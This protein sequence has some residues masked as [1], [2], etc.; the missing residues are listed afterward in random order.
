MPREGYALARGWFRQIDL[1]ENP[2]LYDDP[3]DA[4]RVPALAR[5]ARRALGAAA[6]TPGS[7]RWAPTARPRCSAPGARACGRCTA[8]PTGRSTRCPAR[9]RSSTAGALTRFDHEAIAGHRRP[10][11]APAPRALEPLLA[12]RVRRRLPR[13]GAGRADDARGRAGGPLFPRDRARRGAL[14]Q[15][16][17]SR[18]RSGRV[19][20]MRLRLA[21]PAP[22]GPP[23]GGRR[24][25]RRRR[26]GDADAGQ[27]RAG[28]DRRD[29]HRDGH[30]RRDRDGR[31][32]RPTPAAARP[33][34]AAA[35]ATRRRAR[36]SSPPRAAS[37]AT[38]SPTRAPPARSAR[39][40]TRRSPTPRS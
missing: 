15:G 30:R 5:P 16:R 7:G 23:A 33:P 4:G 10:G 11:P 40:S 32:R 9:P 36:R 25:L 21:L 3:L 37:R 17:L 20:R 28:R 39:T 1:A 18:R 13:A 35:A 38:R 2:E 29:R 27:R 31:R 26:G 6:R 12:R 8:R 14:R 24:G 34:A 22:A 19:A